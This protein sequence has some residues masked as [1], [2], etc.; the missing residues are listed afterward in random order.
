MFNKGDIKQPK[1]DL[2][3]PDDSINLLVN[4]GLLRSLFNHC[5]KCGTK[6]FHVAARSYGVDVTFYIDCRS[7]D[8]VV[9][10]S[11]QPAIPDTQLHRGNLDLTSAVVIPGNTHQDVQDI[12]DMLNLQIMSKNTFYR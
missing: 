1:Q 6:A 7:C 12:A 5:P 3:P 9:E 11:T 4:L 8:E 10:W 2:L